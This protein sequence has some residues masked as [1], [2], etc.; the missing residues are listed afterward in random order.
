MVTAGPHVTTVN[1]LTRRNDP[2]RSHEQEVA[3]CAKMT[4]LEILEGIK[5]IG[6]EKILRV[7]TETK[8]FSHAS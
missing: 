5:L 2:T 3:L 7:E 8:N 6:D 1:K 4:E